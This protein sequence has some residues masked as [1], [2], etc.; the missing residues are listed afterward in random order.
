MHVDEFGNYVI[1]NVKFPEYNVITASDDLTVVEAKQEAQVRA[2]KELKE[3][4]D[5]NF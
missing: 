2:L 3:V 4:L 1:K 5:K